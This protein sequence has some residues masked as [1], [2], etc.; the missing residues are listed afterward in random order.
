LPKGFIMRVVGEVID[1]GKAP[2]ELSFW[3]T[4]FVVAVSVDTCTKDAAVIMTQYGVPLTTGVGE[5]LPSVGP[6]AT[7]VSSPVW[8]RR[9]DGLELLSEYNPSRSATP[10]VTVWTP[11]AA[12]LEVA[13]P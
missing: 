7:L 11:S 1:D 9:A 4:Q 10:P 3:Y 12:T 2:Y 13:A 8:A 5:T 6:P